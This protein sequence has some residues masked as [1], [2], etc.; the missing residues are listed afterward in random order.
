MRH[1]HSIT[2]N[3]GQLIGLVVAAAAVGAV[4]AMLV[5]PRSGGQVR[6]GLKRRAAKAKDSLHN[7]VDNLSDD[8]DE[9]ED[10]IS[11]AATNVAKEAKTAARRAK[12]SASSVASKAKTSAKK[13][14]KPSE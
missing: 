3:P 6:N 5:T 12:R 2:E 4:T 11:A 10:D 8:I 14:R 1:R 9:I 7:H 13:P